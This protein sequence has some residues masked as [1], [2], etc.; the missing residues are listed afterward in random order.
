MIKKK[1]RFLIL[2][3]AISVV[4]GLVFS[5]FDT[6]TKSITEIELIKTPT[7]I[8]QE[9]TPQVNPSINNPRTTGL[10][11]NISGPM[12]AEEL[13][14][15]EKGNVLGSKIFQ[16]CGRDVD[17]VH[18]YMLE[19]SQTESTDVVMFVIDKVIQEW[20]KEK[21]PCHQPAH[22]LGQ[23][24][25]GLYDGDLVEAIS[26]IKHNLC[27]NA[28]YHGILDNYLP[29]KVLLDDIPV[30]DLDINTPC[31]N[32]DSSQSSNAYRQCLHGMGHGLLVAYDFDVLEAVKRCD[33]FRE[34]DDHFWEC[35]EGLFMENHNQYFEN[36]GLGAYKEDDILYPCN[37]LDVKY[38]EACYQYQANI[39]LSRN[40]FDYSETFKICEGLQYEA[41]QKS[42][43]RSVSMYMTNKFFFDDYDKIV[44]MC[45]DENTNH[46][47]SCI[48]G[49]I[50]GI[51]LYGEKD[52]LTEFCPLFQGEQKEYCEF[53][54]YFTLENQDLV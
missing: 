19:L 36:T 17:C 9:H 3:V 20:D 51:T 48:Y 49:S 7:E 35:T 26:N 11:E 47:H 14:Y 16:E 28:L 44:E 53:Y 25:L 32:L 18:N 38:Q 40:N 34:N 39:I 8:I 24:V 29:V 41:S 31:K 45:H 46:P 6:I 2:G 15:Y 43:T 50:Y 37:Y 30:E 33:I 21:L 42:C 10:P 54:Y 22:H 27:G 5:G 4:F 52:A 12:S 1:Y 23:F 13:I